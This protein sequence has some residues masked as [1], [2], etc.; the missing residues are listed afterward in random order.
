MHSHP[1]GPYADAVTSVQEYMQQAGFALPPPFSTSSLFLYRET[2]CTSIYA[3]SK[4]TSGFGC[5][6]QACIPISNGGTEPCMDQEE[7]C[8]PDHE[9]LYRSAGDSLQGYISDCSYGKVHTVKLNHQD[10]GGSHA[11]NHPRSRTSYQIIH[12]LETC[13]QGKQAMGNLIPKDVAT[14]RSMDGHRL[15]DGNEQENK[16]KPSPHKASSMNLQ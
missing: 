7:T 9:R 3:L 14:V 12:S 6:A 16:L 10:V 8:A 11:Q 15:V 4:K 13:I 2:V 5:S 1:E